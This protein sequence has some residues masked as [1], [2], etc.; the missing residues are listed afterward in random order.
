MRPER[1]VAGT[2]AVSVAYDGVDRPTSI[3]P[4]S[5]PAH[6]LTYTP[7]GAFSSYAPPAGGDPLGTTTV[8]HDEAQYASS[9]VSGGRGTGYERDPRTGRLQGVTLARGR[10]DAH[11]DALGRLDAMEGPDGARLEWAWDGPLLS[12]VSASGVAPGEIS[13]EHDPATFEIAAWSV[14]GTRIAVERDADGVSTRIGD[15]VFTR[16]PI[17]GDISTVAL[18]STLSVRTLDD[19]GEITRRT[20]TRAGTTVYDEQVLGR[21]ALGRVL[22]V[23]ETVL[24]VSHVLDY[25]YDVADR[26]SDVQQD[27]APVEHYRYDP[28][29][30]R[31]SFVRRGESGSATVSPDDRPRTHGARTFTYLADGS[32][33]TAVDPA[34]STRYDLDEVGTLLGV[35]LPDGRRIDYDIDPVGRRV[36]RRVDGV[37]TKGWLYF[38]DLAPVAETNAAGVITTVFVTGPGAMTPELMIRAGARY[39]FVTDMRG[40]VR[41]VIDEATGAVAQ[42]I[43]YD[44]FGRVLSDTSPGL[45][46]FGFAGGLY[47]P[48]TQL[49][50]FGAR[51]Y[52]ADTGT[53]LSADP[54]AFGGGLNFYDYAG[55][56][57]V[58]RID[59]NGEWV[60]LLPLVVGAVEG[61]GMGFGIRAM[62]HLA[63]GGS[64]Y[65]CISTEN[66]A[67]DIA[68]DAFL[69]AATAG[70]GVIAADGARAA[71]GS[72]G[73]GGACRGGACASMERLAIGRGRDLAGPGG[74]RPGEFKFEWPSRLP[75]WRAEWGINDG[76]LRNEMHHMRPI[77]DASPGDMEGLFLNAERNLLESRGWHDWRTDALT[78][79]WLPPGGG[80]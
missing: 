12:A 73:L 36:G 27:A 24:G 46:P 13:F 6:G 66:L 3:A 18:G 43:D 69:G 63:A 25:A 7:S 8:T 52:D 77:R 57:P 37:L 29:G 15:L 48:D 59:V 1:I 65:D 31:Q 70:L 80:G 53:W 64:V 10:F 47:D 41:L 28:N 5:R 58:N 20:F 54:S 45:Q 60:F 33:Q 55:G 34:G 38:G 22:R 39:R 72:R 78:T 35:V 74:L 21:D 14:G 62:L 71:A 9:I 32:R 40:S 50:R 42:R 75:D 30:A 16:D 56:D 49:V 61:I 19:F 79:S 44:A 23:R 67:R 76:L 2:R 4:P 51:D 68:T 11:Y 26:L 17:Q